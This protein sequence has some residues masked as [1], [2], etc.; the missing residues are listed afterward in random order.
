MNDEAKGEE[1]I[2]NGQSSSDVIHITMFHY[3][4]QQRTPRS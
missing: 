2:S 3:E 1:A 4:E